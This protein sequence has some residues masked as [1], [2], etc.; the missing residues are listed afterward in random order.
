MTV[1][2]LH[3][4]ELKAFCSSQG[5]IQKLFRSQSTSAMKHEFCSPPQQWCLKIREIMQNCFEGLFRGADR[6]HLVKKETNTQHAA[7]YFVAHANKPVTVLKQCG[8][9]RHEVEWPTMPF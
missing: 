4:R 8:H 2:L 5:Q 6:S 1:Q 9:L 7:R 3:W